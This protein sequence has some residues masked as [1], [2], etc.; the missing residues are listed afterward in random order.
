MLGKEVKEMEYKKY[1]VIYGEFRE[2]NNECLQSGSRPAIVLSNNLGNKYSPTLLVLPLSSHIKKLNMPTHKLIKPD[3]HNGLKVNSMV[4]AE[5]VTTINKNMVVKIGR[6]DDRALQK[7][8]FKCF[9]YSAAFGDQD[10]D[11][12]EL[13]F[14]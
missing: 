3:S 11:L 9:I 10:E 6:I 2:S 7:E 8:I 4:L 12:Q 1:D 14:S 13:Q 5:Q